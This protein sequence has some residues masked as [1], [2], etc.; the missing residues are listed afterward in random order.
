MLFSS[1]LPSFPLSHS[2][3]IR[4]GAFWLNENPLLR[5]HLKV[6]F[7]LISLTRMTQITIF[8][9]FP[10]L[11]CTL[12]SWLSSSLELSQFSDLLSS[13]SDF[14][15]ASSPTNVRK[16]NIG[17]LMR[18]HN[19][20]KLS[21]YPLKPKALEGPPPTVTDLPIPCTYPCSSS[22]FCFKQ[23]LAINHIGQPCLF[24]FI[25]PYSTHFIV[26]DPISI[27]LLNWI[28]K[29]ENFLKLI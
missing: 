8:G 17:S 11:P 16:I 5:G 21:Q 29:T 3:L 12:I 2:Q 23:D 14:L 9:G 15:W 18:F 19:V 28:L 22:V 25:S 4:E 1:D 26:I 27:F 6:F 24:G 10:W 13:V 20:L 7:F